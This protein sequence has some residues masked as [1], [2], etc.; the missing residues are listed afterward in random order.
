MSKQSAQTE[1]AELSPSG[2]LLS[3]EPLQGSD[4]SETLKLSA[5]DTDGSDTLSDADGTDKTDSDTT[6]GTDTEGNDGTYGAT[7]DTDGTDGESTDAD[8][9]DS[10]VDADSVDA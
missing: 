6:G 3:I 2:L 7:P 8:G 9:T 1:N 4:P 5:D 10:T